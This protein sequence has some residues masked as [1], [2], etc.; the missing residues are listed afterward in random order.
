M[1]KIQRIIFLLFTWVALAGNAFAVAPENGW[2]WNSSESGSGYAIERQGNSI[3][4][5]AFLYETSGAATW[6]ATLLSLQPDGTYKGDMTRYVGGKSLLGTYKAPTSSSVVAV[7]SASFQFPDLGT[8]TISFMNGAPSRTITIKRFGFSNPVFDPSPA[9]FQSGWWWNDKESGTGYFIEVQGNGAFIANF[10]YDTTG[11]PTWYASLA[12]LSGTNLLSGPLDM[13]SNGQSLGGPYKA[14]AVNA[15]GAGAMKYGFSGEAQ[16]NMTLPNNA[17]VA[18]KRFVFDPSIVSNHA[19]LPNAGAA[20]TVT[21]G[22]TVY[23]YGSGTDADNDLLTFSWRY[24]AAPTGSNASL[25][26][27]QTTRPYFVPDLAGTYRFEL[28]ADDGKVGN[29]GSVVTVTANPKAV[30][31]IPPVANAG[32]N[33]TINVGT[34][35][36]LSGAAS[37]DVNGDPLNYSWFFVSKPVGSS[38]SL[39]FPQSISPTFT[40]DIAG[41]YI[42]SLIVNDGKLNSQEATVIINVLEIQKLIPDCN[43]LNCPAVGGNNY[44]G[45]GIGFWKYKNTTPNDIYLDVS[46]NGVSATDEVNLIFSNGQN[47]D[48]SSAPNQGIKSLSFTSNAAPQLNKSNETS[49]A[50][51]SHYIDLLDLKEIKKEIK[52]IKT[53][54]NKEGINF[55]PSISN[56]I[57]PK[58]GDTK[59]WIDTYNSGSTAYSARAYNICTIGG[60][61]NAIFWVDPNAITNYGISN[62]SL[63][64]LASSFCGLNGAAALLSSQLGAVWGAHNY[65]SSHISDAN[66]Q[67]LNILILN[68]PTTSKWGGYHAGSNTFLKSYSSK[69][70]NSNEAIAIF[71]HP[72]QINSNNISYA[73][74]TLIHEMTHAI[75]Y[76]QQTILNQGSHDY[77][78]WLEE[79][80]ALMSEDLISPLK[81]TNSDGSKFNPTIE[82]RIPTYMKSGGGVNLIDW[83]TLSNASYAMGASFGAFLLRQY[84]SEIHKKMINCTLPS[85]TC[86]DNLIK[87]YGGNGIQEDFSKFGSSIFSHLPDTVLP[88]GYGFPSNTN[89][90]FPLDSINILN[91]KNNLSSNP[92]PMGNNFPKTTHYYIKDIIPAGQ[93]TYNRKSIKV[94]SGT[95]INL[96]I[97]NNTDFFGAIAVDT[98]TANA[99][100]AYGYQS[101]V[102]A[103]LSAINYCNSSSCSVKITFGTGLCGAFARGLNNNGSYGMGWSTASTKAQAE[104]NATIGCIPYGGSNCKA[105]LSGCN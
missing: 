4:M 28:I 54:S 7:A 95:E 94:P 63:D 16:G 31:N 90:S 104:L 92:S 55:A 93:T 34:T 96:T 102:L 86:I 44:S 75:N 18:I 61:R 101:Q 78:T 105:L 83:T 99:G 22:S 62:S 85:Y 21:V 13:Y 100:I 81:I 82:N 60:N 40:P 45:K 71:L 67:D 25:F 5:A 58:I 65:T 103:N 84:S 10:M 49:E 50:N 42:I 69:Y 88:K 48:I 59:I 36:R 76:F 29:G 41:T 33:Q 57:A 47:L 80:S 97:Q 89:S 98:I 72:N 53:T 2:W 11:Q 9:S 52:S 77:D 15:G 1:S 8:L 32:P 74:S 17:Q 87:S 12:T 79:T 30:V 23:L 70:S 39:L 46:I 26:N 35:A 68:V 43:G 27:W 24:L 91:I 37:S 20:Q 73:A 6:Y 66:S 38:A 56:Y 3:F 19:P 51:I 64:K 14:P